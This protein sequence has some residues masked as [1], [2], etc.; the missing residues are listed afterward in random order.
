MKQNNNRLVFHVDLDILIRKSV[1]TSMQLCVFLSHLLHFPHIQEIH[2]SF[3]KWLH[4]NV[5]A[6]GLIKSSKMSLKFMPF[7]KPEMEITPCRMPVITELGDFSSE[8]FSVETYR[9][10]LQTKKLGKIV[11]FAEVTSTTMNLLDG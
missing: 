10:N 4:Q 9:H 8:H 11:L 2:A 5:D 3:L 1:C 7:Y 6:E